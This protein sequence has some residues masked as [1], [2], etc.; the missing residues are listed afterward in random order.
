MAQR[1]LVS[2]LRSIG[3]FLV[4]DGFGVASA[5]IF[6]IVLA[7]VRGAEELG[8]FSFSMAQ[9]LLLQLVVEAN[10]AITLP[11]QVARAG[12]IAEPLRQAQHAKWYLALLGVPI[13]LGL[14]LLLGRA[15]A[16]VSTMAAFAVTV[17]HSFVGSYT[18]ALHGLGQMTVL[19]TIIAVSTTL[20]ALGGIAAVVA[21]LPLPAVVLVHG[22][23]TALPLWVWSGRLLQRWEPEWSPWQTYAGEV[24]RQACSSGWRKAARAVLSTLRQRWYWIALGILTI[25]YMRFGVLLLGWIG[26]AAAD[27]GA[28]SAAQRFVVVLRILPNAFF[29]V[30][31]P[32]FTKQPEGFTVGWALA[33]SLFIGVP[34]AALLHAGAPWLMELTFRIPEAVP[35]LQLMGWALP[36]VMLSHV[37]ESYALTFPRHQ[38]SIVVWAAV[39][40]GLGFLA[41]LWSFQYWAAMAVAAVYVGM[42]TL[43]ALGIV[44]LVHRDRRTQ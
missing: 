2:L 8:L 34:L 44:L 39:V 28:Y 35:L 21:G 42:E 29:R 15:D 38:R 19:G 20:G 23:G 6:S 1:S 37:A 31:L 12:R 27:L 14:T 5:V 10:F 32:Q 36:G 18:A 26:A 40:L 24:V 43:Y 22:L 17:V 13:G 7:R 25:G 4:A 9:G 16:I 11:Q 30:F 3:A 41:A 33:L